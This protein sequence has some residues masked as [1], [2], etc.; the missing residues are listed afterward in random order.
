MRKIQGKIRSDKAAKKYRR[1]L[2][3]RS[4]LSGTT[5]RPRVCVTKSNKNLFVQVIDDSAGKTLFS[6]QTFGK[7]ATATGNS[8]DSAK[9]L[10]A[11]VGDEL[12]SRDLTTI[13][14]DRSG[15][16]YSGVLSTLADSIRESGIKF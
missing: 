7:N 1:K 10:G 6:V 12:K 4:K 16:S 9:Q 14:F 2:N 8:K 13:V 11:K 5:E 15:N 3:I